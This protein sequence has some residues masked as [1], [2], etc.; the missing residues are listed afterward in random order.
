[1]KYL[2]YLSLHT[3]ICLDFARILSGIHPLPVWIVVYMADYFIVGKST[4][5]MKYVRWKGLILSIFTIMVFVTGPL[6]GTYLIH[7][8]HRHLHL[9]N[10]FSSHYR[11]TWL[12]LPFSFSVLRFSFP[13]IK[14]SFYRH[15]AGPLTKIWICQENMNKQDW[16]GMVRVLK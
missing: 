13:S 7:Q 16:Q 14:F 10:G 4:L 15:R 11:H 5:N 6:N 2:L 3:Q 1:M 12:L 8:H 9:K